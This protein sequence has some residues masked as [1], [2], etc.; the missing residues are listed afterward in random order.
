MKLAWVETFVA[1][2][3]AGSIRGAARALKVSQPVVTSNIRSLE[4]ELALP[5]IHRSARG[6]VLTEFGHAFLIHARAIHSE[7]AKAAESMSRLAGMRRSTI[8]L[9]TSPSA[10]VSIVPDAIAKLHASGVDAMVRIVECYPESAISGLRDGT[11]DFLIGPQGALARLPDIAIEPLF[12][13]EMLVVCRKG[14]PK[15]RERSLANVVDIP[16]IGG[17]SRV[18]AGADT[19]RRV[20]EHVGVPLPEVWVQSES[21]LATIG[22]VAKSDLL[23]LVISEV[24]YMGGHEQV[25]EPLKL[26]ERLRATVCLFT[27][28]DSPLSPQ[29][30]AL[31]KLLR[32]EAKRKR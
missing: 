9:G 26:N 22:M 3:D 4:R 32:I 2:A 21:H 14:H 11:F 24:V 19:L 13:T 25:I 8:N 20:C 15:R 23:G 5:L 10:A 28:V 27:R 7:T 30:Q 12:S 6:A 29:A 18:P 16:W 1:L 17:P 31:V